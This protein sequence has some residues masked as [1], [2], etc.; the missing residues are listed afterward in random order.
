MEVLLPS[1]LLYH[2]VEVQKEYPRMQMQTVQFWQRADGKQLSR[3]MGKAMLL[4]ITQLEGTIKVKI[5]APQILS[6]R[7]AGVQG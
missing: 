1:T 5:F 4:G 2:R 3:A 7:L 6:N